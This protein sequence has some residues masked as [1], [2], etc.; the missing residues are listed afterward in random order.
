MIKIPKKRKPLDDLIS[1]I[2]ACEAE[3]SSLKQKSRET[4]V[5]EGGLLTKAKTLLK[6]GEWTDWLQSHFSMTDKTARKYMALCRLA[7]E[8]GMEAVMALANIRDA[9][10]S[11]PGSVL[12][13][14]MTEIA[15][16]ANGGEAIVPFKKKTK[17]HV[18]KEPPTHI[19][20]LFDTATVA[21]YNELE[22]KGLNDL[23]KALK[24]Y[25]PE[26]LNIDR[27]LKPDQ[28]A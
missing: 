5:K 26:W 10:K 1:E 17:G 7:D 2:K 24:I 15:S 13:S 28:A 20:E 9:S 21:I 6:H 18:V 25:G 14:P 3:L 4:I 11:E 27:I 12:T 16:I 19:M 23:V 8:K 22:E